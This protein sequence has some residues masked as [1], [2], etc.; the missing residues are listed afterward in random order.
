MCYNRMSEN[1]SF[2]G[3]STCDCSLAFVTL[4]EYFYTNPSIPQYLNLS[5]LRDSWSHHLHL[6]IPLSGLF[7]HH[8]MEDSRGDLEF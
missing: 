6:P 2:T 7:H 1:W 8:H 3:C 5:P 4:Q